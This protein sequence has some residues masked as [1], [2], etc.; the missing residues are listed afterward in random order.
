MQAAETGGE[1]LMIDGFHAANILKEKYPDSYECLTSFIVP[2]EYREATSEKSPGFHM[3]NLCPVITTHP[4]SGELIK[5][6]FV[7]SHL[8]YQIFLKIR[9]Y[10]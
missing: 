4:A 3:Y 7:L 9:D 2:H 10:P 5:I 8:R 6:R 1:T